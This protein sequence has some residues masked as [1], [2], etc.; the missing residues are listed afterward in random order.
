MQVVEMAGLSPKNF[1]ANIEAKAPRPALYLRY[2]R[3]TEL[4]KLGFG[5]FES[6]PKMEE[7][8]VTKFSQ[9]LNFILVR[10]IA[11]NFRLEQFR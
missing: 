9:Y 1:P 11:E 6:A 10:Q 5:C 7:V 8:Q 2:E 4:A 3:D